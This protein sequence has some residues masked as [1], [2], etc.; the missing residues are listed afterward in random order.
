MRMRP[1]F[2]RL[3][4]CLSLTLLV[5][6]CLKGQQEQPTPVIRSS[7]NEV[8]VPVVVRDTRGQAVGNL[9]KDNFQVFDNGKQQAITG[10]TV[11]KRAT[12]S[13]T[14]SSVSSSE[15]TDSPAVSQPIF[16]PQRFVVFL[17]DDY[18]LTFADLPHAQQAAIK[19]LESLAPADFA[20]VLSTFGVNSGMT[21]DHEKLKQAILDLKVKTLLRTDEHNCHNVDYYQ[22]NQIVNKSDVLALQVATLEVAYCIKHI[23]PEAAESIAQTDAARAVQ[24]GEQNYRAN[25]GSLRLILNKLMAPLPGQHIIVVISPGFFAPGTEAATIK[26]EILDLAAR[27]NTVINT[28]DTRGLYTTNVGSDVTTRVDPASQR[29]INQYHQASMEADSEVM[30][31]LA[32]GTGGTFYHNNNDIEA[33]L[34]TLI[35]GANYTYFL[36]FSIKAKPRSSHNLKVKVN[37]PGL[38]VQARRGYTIPAPEKQKK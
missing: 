10:F 35:S 26:S 17:F 5:A 2:L 3:I 37:Q 38:T 9:V 15:P 21:R 20:L 24:L 4:W 1:E 11:V 33:G 25:L 19:A 7:V 27:T 18:N 28:I 32:D 8:L 30:E 23:V 16:P 13:E 12:V 31:E 29:L 14:N 22:G 34:K 6:F 36:A